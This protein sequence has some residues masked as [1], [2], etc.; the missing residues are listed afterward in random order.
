[1]SARAPIVLVSTEVDDE[2]RLKLA[3]R[4]DAVAQL[5]SPPGESIVNLDPDWRQGVRVLVV[6]GSSRLAT[7]SMSL[8]PSLELVACVGSGYEGIDLEGARSLGIA[9]TH[10]PGAS[11]SS[12]A[13][14]ALGLLIG[15]ARG[16]HA[17]HALLQRGTW[18]EQAGKSDELL[19]GLTNRR[20]G[21][22]G[23]GAIGG[24]IARRASAFEMAVGYHSRR[25]RAGVDYAWFA[26]LLDLADWADF[27][28]VA[29]PATRGTLRA[30]DH[31]VLAA[32]GPRGYIINIARG[33]VIDEPAMIES[34]RNGTIAGAGL[35]V[36]DNEPNVCPALLAMPN[37]LATPHIGGN[38]G[39][40]WEKMRQ[41]VLANVEALFAGRP[42]LNPVPLPDPFAGKDLSRT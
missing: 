38:T 31:A 2:L 22:F 14:L 25:Q 19:P 8:L 34:L 35:D 40:G 29:V 6:R 12:V 32:L 18:P 37:V 33:S 5:A 42:V 4:Y 1:M 41:M 11:A 9:V 17:G 39:H 24:K 23:L 3:R 10:S 26:S 15:I 28:V 36:F 30:V 20:V 13:D 7:A 16:V 21:I 27:L